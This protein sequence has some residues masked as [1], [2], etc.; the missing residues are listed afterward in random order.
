LAATLLAAAGCSSTYPKAEQTYEFLARYDRMSNQ[1]EPL[2]SLVYLPDCRALRDCTGIVVGQVEVGSHRVA[3]RDKARRF[4]LILRHLLQIKLRKLKEFDFVALEMDEEAGGA[5]NG[6]VYRLDSM[7][8]KFEMGSSWKRYWSWYILM[9]AGATDLQIEGRVT[10]AQTGKVIMEFADRRRHLGNTPWGPNPRNLRSKDFAMKQTVME[11]AD[12]L[13][14]FI[15][16]ARDG[17]NAAG[18]DP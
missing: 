5:A 14:R 7:I 3:E 13:S 9:Q 12:C 2:L 8:T 11:T 1:H 17:P 15:Q 16:T 6:P 4:A 18:S 10:D